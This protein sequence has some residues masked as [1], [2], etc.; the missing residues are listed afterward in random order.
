MVLHKP[1]VVDARP[2]SQLDLVEHARE[3][4]VLVVRRPQPRQLVLV[5]CRVSDKLDV[6]VRD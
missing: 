2:V 3:E 6:S 1:E 5:D 4:A